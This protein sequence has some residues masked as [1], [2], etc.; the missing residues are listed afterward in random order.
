MMI[1][2]YQRLFLILIM[3]T[4]GCTIWI[5]LNR[6]QL[7]IN[8]I[9]AFICAAICM[10]AGVLFVKV[11]AFAESGFNDEKLD[12]MSLFGGVFL[13]PA[14]LAAGA[15]LAKRNMG[16]VF[17][18][19]GICM[20]WTMFCMRVNCLFAGCCIGRPIHGLDMRW[21]TREA[22]ML[23]YAVFLAIFAPKVYKKECNGKL[24]PLYMLSY[25]VF[26]FIIEFFRDSSAGG[27]LHIAHVWAALC[28]L[29]G[30]GLYWEIKSR[31]KKKQST[32]KR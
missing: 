30:L 27:I 14:L 32:K 20:P 5:G 17:D 10:G 11:F 31:L 3:A 2:G 25:G 8:W 23:F 22:E 26:R 9:A 6:K 12:K 24:Y 1:T 18:I 7:R 15:K 29:I 4:V 21:P 13:M 28:A 19:F 16:D